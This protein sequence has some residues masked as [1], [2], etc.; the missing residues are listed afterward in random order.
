MWCL[1]A[2][3]VLTISS[4]DLVNPEVTD[5]FVAYSVYHGYRA[6][7]YIVETADGYLL[8]LFRIPGFLN[9]TVG[10]E[11]PVA[12]MQHGLLDNCDT[13]IVN[14]PS[15]APGFLMA[16]AGF[17]VWFGNS[18]GSKYSLSH[19]NMTTKNAAFWA[20]SWQEMGQYDIPAEIDY[21]LETTGAQTLTYIGHSQGTTQMYALLSEYPEFSSKLNLYVGLGPVATVRNVTLSLLQIVNCTEFVDLLAKYHIYDVMP[22]TNAPVFV[23]EA[24]RIFGL[25]CSSVVEYLTDLISS[26]DNTPRFPVI[27]A[28]E[29]GGTSIQNLQHWAQMSTLPAYRMQ[30]YDY[31]AAGNLQHYGQATPPVYNLSNVNVPHAMFLGV[32]DKLADPVD[33]A[34]LMTQLRTIIYAETNLP[35]GHL[36]FMWGKNADWFQTVISLAHQYSGAITY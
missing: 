16:N 36:T 7:S 1:I 18:R 28:H 34:W 12:F 5:L 33:G 29:P 10:V 4:A 26:N 23:Y 32:D 13:W 31:G 9:E 14:D 3:L 27:L 19:V 11:K 30:K 25:V 2:I 35:A 24:C 15:L 17:D 22:Y 6:E 20:F 21:V 8:T